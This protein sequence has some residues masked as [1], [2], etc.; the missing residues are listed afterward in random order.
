[1]CKYQL[2]STVNQKGALPPMFVRH[3]DPRQVFI[4]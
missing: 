3:V 4:N 2:T 1:M